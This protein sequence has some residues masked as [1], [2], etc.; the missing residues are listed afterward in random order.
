MNSRVLSLPG[1]TVLVGCAG[2]AV[3][4]IGSTLIAQRTSVDIQAEALSISAAA[5]PSRALA[6]KPI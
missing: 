6:A 3:A 1:H 4:F 2:I 5:A